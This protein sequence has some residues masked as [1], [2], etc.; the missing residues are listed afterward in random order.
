MPP[1]TILIDADACPVKDEIYRV[2]EHLRAEVL[3]VRIPFALSSS[4]FPGQIFD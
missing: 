3:V 1:S 4:L 2:A